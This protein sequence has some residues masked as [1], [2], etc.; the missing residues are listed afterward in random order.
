MSGENEASVFISDSQRRRILS[1]IVVNYY[2]PA[3]NDKVVF[4][5]HRGWCAHLDLLGTLFSSARVVC[6]V[7]DLVWILDSMERLV[8]N[9]CLTASRIF[10]FSSGGNVYTRMDQLMKGGFVGSSV[11]ALREAWFGPQ[12][13]R[14]IVV[15]YDS[16]VNHPDVTIE[17]L[18]RELSM[19]PFAHD[20]ASLKYE[21]P[22]LDAY[23][24]WPG[25]HA[26]RSRVEPSV[27]R[28][29]L[30]VD[31]VERYANH[32]FWNSNDGN[33]NGVVVL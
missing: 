21:S 16:L 31:I 30:P 3:G 10:G 5:N 19:E 27:R 17:R 20:F 23:I 18:Y 7:R 25:M 13:H 32:D 14:L 33:P 26:V 12:A 29:I 2:E 9:N 22:E 28:T 15:R 24:G 8:R 1:G 11:H 6:C 4:D